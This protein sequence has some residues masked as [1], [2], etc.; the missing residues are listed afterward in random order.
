MYFM[1]NEDL[2]SVFN[3]NV[4]PYKNNRMYFKCTDSAKAENNAFLKKQFSIVTHSDRK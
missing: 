1:E 4:S 3:S 2:Y